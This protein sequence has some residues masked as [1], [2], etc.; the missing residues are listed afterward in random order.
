MKPSAFSMRKEEWETYFL[1]NG[2][3]KFRGQ[4]V[5]HWIFRK[6]CLNP[7]KMVNLPKA[8]Q[9]DL[10]ASFSWE[11]PQISSRVEAEDG[12]TKLLL[13]AH[14]NR[15][16]ETVTMR[17]ANRTSL[18][19]SSQVGCRLACSF[20]QTGKLGFFRHLTVEEILGQMFTA[21]QILKREGKKVS[22]V[23][24]MGMGEPLDNYE[25]A[26]KSANIMIEDFGLS[27]KNVT[28]STSGITPK[29]H[30]L[31]HESPASLA[32]S[33]HAANDELRSQLMPINKRHNLAHLKTA[34]FDY[35]RTTGQKLTIEYI[36]IKGVNDSRKH[37]KELVSYLHG[38][39][40]KV[41][42]IPFNDHPGIEYSRPDDC[43]IREFQKYLIDRSFAAPVRYSKGLE[44]SAACGQ[45]A[46]KAA[47]E[48]NL[49]PKRSNVIA[50]DRR[51]RP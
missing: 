16:I 33:L 20:C 35:Q 47:G 17:Y 49:Q 7:G 48:R 10:S 2:L 13:K 27:K 5:Y 44:A 24:F 46:A 21:N 43:S 50:V 11:L 9:Q 28:I 51:P 4:Q 1:G 41:N 30:L 38:L 25:N 23:V 36:L 45:L 26:V 18:C 22:H 15:L 34:L 8:I 32:I 6:E 29:I 37:A 40:A 39:R 19:V 31:A 12:T 42:L 14:D 3:P